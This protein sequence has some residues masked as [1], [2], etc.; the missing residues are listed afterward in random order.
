MKDTRLARILHW[1]PAARADPQI[2]PEKKHFS[3]NLTKN[4]HTKLKIKKTYP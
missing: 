3:N 1:I 4:T 2:L